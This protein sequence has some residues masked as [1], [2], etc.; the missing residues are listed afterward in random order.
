[1]GGAISHASGAA[2]QRV[3][4]GMRGCREGFSW[5]TGLGNLMGKRMSK[6]RAVD[7]VTQDECMEQKEKYVCASPEEHS[8]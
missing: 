2:E 4:I 7:E 1:M 8:I 3:P 5:K 6:D